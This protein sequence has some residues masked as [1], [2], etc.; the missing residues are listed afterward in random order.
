MSLLT[1]R[2]IVLHHI[3]YGDSSIIATIYTE[4]H[5]KQSFIINGVHS[6]KSKMKI[7]LFQP[8]SLLDLE[9]Y[10]KPN[11]DIHRIK[12]AKP[13]LMFSNIPQD[14][15]KSSVG[16]FIAEILY[17]TLYEEESNSPLF[18]FISKTIEL[19]EVESKGIENF[20]LFFLVK[21]SRFLGIMPEQKKLK[22]DIYFDL[23]EGQFT[24]I[25][26]FHGVF[27]DK[28]LSKTLHQL[29]SSNFEDIAT[30]KISHEIRQ[31]LL[32]K[33]IEYYYFHLD[34]MGEIKSHHILREV[35]H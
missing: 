35:F 16:I 9:V 13:N 34:K 8:L 11:R 25:T 32:D 18:N 31:K 24:N 23:Q 28:E 1:T 10:Y 14:M 21:Y 12:E 22:E 30:I 5:G 15:T 2:G 6:K 29:Q 3:K 7:G 27:L 4:V 33:L 26:P 19:L 17:R 20:H